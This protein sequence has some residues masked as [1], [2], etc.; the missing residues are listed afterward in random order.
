MGEALIVRRGGT[1]GGGS[2]SYTVAFTSLLPNGTETITYTGTASGTVNITSGTASVTL[3]GGTYR[4]VSSNTD[5]DSGDVAITGDTTIN[6]YYGTPLFWYGTFNSSIFTNSW[7]DQYSS[8][9]VGTSISVT[10][11]G[12]SSFRYCANKSAIDFTPYSAL[13]MY[14][15]GSTS[16]ANYHRVGVTS[17]N[18]S[19]KANVFTSIASQGAKALREIDLSAVNRTGYIAIGAQDS[20]RTTTVYALWLV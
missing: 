17:S 5:W 14:S 8:H 10:G 3:D 11:T 12:S 13:R 9:S 2:G 19:P 15:A 18:T 4:F 16:N 7:T 1:G 20:G 6:C